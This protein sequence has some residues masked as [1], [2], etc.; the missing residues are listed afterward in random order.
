MY[1][2]LVIFMLPKRGSIKLLRCLSEPAFATY[3]LIFCMK[4]VGKLIKG[5]MGLYELINTFVP[6]K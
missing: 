2:E 1:G 4:T 3:G 5:V 6:A